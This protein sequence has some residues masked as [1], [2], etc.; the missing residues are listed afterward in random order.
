MKAKRWRLLVALLILATFSVTLAPA[1][2]KEAITGAAA[3]AEASP[4]SLEGGWQSTIKVQNL[5]NRAGTVILEFRDT[6]GKVVGEGV[7][8]E[9]TAGGNLEVNLNDLPQKTLPPGRYGAVISSDVPI[10]AVATQSNV[11]DGIADSYPA[12]L[13]AKTV[14]IPYVFRRLNDWYTTLFIQNTSQDPA[15]YEFR[16]GGVSVRGSISGGGNEAIDLGASTFGALGSSFSGSG[17][18][19]ASQNVA[20]V[21]VQARGAGPFQAMVATLGI[22]AV[23]ASAVVALPSLYKGVNGWRSRLQV[24][25]PSAAQRVRVTLML[26]PDQGT[27]AGGPW[28]RSGINIEPGGVYELDLAADELLVNDFR[29]SAIIS[30]DGVIEAAV[31]HTNLDKGVA[32]GYGGVPVFGAKSRVS[33]P[34]LYKNFGAGSWKSGI[35]I[36]NLDSNS[37]TVSVTF[38]GDEG[39]AGGVWKKT[40]IVLRPFG[41]QELYLDGLSL[42][43]GKVLPDGFKGS[44]VVEAAAVA[45]HV[46][47]TALHTNY[48][49]GVAV[50]YNGIAY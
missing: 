24:R 16:V 31:I 13:G 9:I 28:V 49:Q 26:R 50:M 23:D 8:R 29:G 10:A 42:D 22:P 1:E 19:E 35:K 21:V 46:A 11:S 4:L 7:S 36:Q 45:A 15:L 40:G 43:G 6:S 32:T 33:L 18:L 3:F 47:A 30:G 17:V 2:S 34:V 37:A 14:D 27:V 41:S 39:I 5:G 12:S 44:A 25:N 48:V 20:V 38:R